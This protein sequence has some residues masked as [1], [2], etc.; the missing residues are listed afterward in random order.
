MGAPVI[1]RRRPAPLGANDVTIDLSG[2]GP[3]PSGDPGLLHRGGVLLKPQFFGTPP[4]LPAPLSQPEVVRAAIASTLAS[5]LATLVDFEVVEAGG[6]RWMRTVSKSRA[7]GRAY[8]WN[9]ALQ[10]HLADCWWLIQM[11]TMDLGTTGLREVGVMM[12]Q[13]QQGIE[14]PP[15]PPPVPLEAGQPLPMPDRTVP[16]PRL[17]ADDEQWDEWFPDHA[18]SR[19]RAAQRAVLSGVR[20]S[21]AALAAAPFLGPKAG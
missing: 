16:P 21:P 11:Q 18:L 9:G 2:W 10:L 20:L 14:P 6:G 15:G 19:L 1:W 8:F 17:A 12:L 13:L 4:D 7:E 5:Q 3:G